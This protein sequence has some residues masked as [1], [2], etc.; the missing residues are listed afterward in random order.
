MEKEKKK[1]LS[2]WLREE[3][4]EVQYFLSTSGKNELWKYYPIHYLLPQYNQLWEELVKL[5]VHVEK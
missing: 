1:E 2:A 4:S 3:N 5:L